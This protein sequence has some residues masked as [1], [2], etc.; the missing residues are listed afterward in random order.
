[1]TKR[2]RASAIIFI[3]NKLIT[4][5]RQ[6]FEGCILK[7]YYTIPG[8]GVENGESI[9]DAVKREILEEIGITVEITDKYFY[10]EKEETDEYFYIANYVSGDIGTGTGPEFTSRN[11]E[12]Y[13]TYEIRLVQKEDIKEINLLPQEAKEYILKNLI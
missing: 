8:G 3:D 1:M 13:G 6:K 9:I 12:K 5:Y 7:T 10:L 2:I 4:V 11:I